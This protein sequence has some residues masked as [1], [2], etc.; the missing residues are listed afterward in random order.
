MKDCS[1]EV[2]K[3]CCESTVHSLSL[4]ILFTFT[5]LLYSHSSFVI[6]PY[7]NYYHTSVGTKTYEQSFLMPFRH[8]FILATYVMTTYYRMQGLI[9]LIHLIPY[10]YS[11]LNILHRSTQFHTTDKCQQWLLIRSLGFIQC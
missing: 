7:S 1:I 3:K 11:L 5:Y 2:F 8:T 9:H 4:L 6:S 10:F